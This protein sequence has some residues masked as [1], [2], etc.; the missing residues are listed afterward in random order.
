MENE[1]PIERNLRSS[2]RE[3][4]R[5]KVYFRASKTVFLIRCEEIINL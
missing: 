4:N 1:E 3:I 2:K 5:D